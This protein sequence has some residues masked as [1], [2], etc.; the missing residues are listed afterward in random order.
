MY[1]LEEIT[2]YLI[3][4]HWSYFKCNNLNQTL[5]VYKIPAKEHQVVDT[6]NAHNI[7]VSETLFWKYLEY[8]VLLILPNWKKKPKASKI[9]RFWISSILSVQ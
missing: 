3:T 5:N 7:S 1:V 2:I 6:W 9:D 8:V 4:T